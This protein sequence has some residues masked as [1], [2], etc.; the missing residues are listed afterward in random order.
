VPQRV[1]VSIEGTSVHIRSLPIGR[2]AH[3]R[4]LLDNVLR[5]L[6]ALRCGR[7]HGSIRVR[8]RGKGTVPGVAVLMHGCKTSLYR[9]R[10]RRFARLPAQTVGKKLRH[11]VARRIHVGR[12]QPESLVPPDLAPMVV[13]IV[14]FLTI[15]F[16]AVFR[17]I[18]KPLIRLFEAMIR[19]REQLP[20]RHL[21]E[22]QGALEQIDRRLHLI[23]E[24]QSFYEALRSDRELQALDAP[25]D[26]VS[27]LPSDR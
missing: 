23:E 18:A 1:S 24:R 15:G 16:V 12:H 17:P 7:S 10:I 26:P 2:A 25:V 6:A 27:V 5:D 11:G 9:G 14:L 13:A 3:L 4:Y 19:E 20:A 21:G 8:S 22:I